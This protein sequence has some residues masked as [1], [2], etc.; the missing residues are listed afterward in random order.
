[1]GH[2]IIRVTGSPSAVL[3]DNAMLNSKTMTTILAAAAFAMAQTTAAQAS[4][5]TDLEPRVLV[6][7]TAASS[8]AGSIGM[9]VSVVPRPVRARTMEKAPAATVRPKTADSPESG[10][11]TL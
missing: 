3:E 6:S 11:E 10:A 5:S 8:R 4:E 7:T 9:R 2:R 1:M